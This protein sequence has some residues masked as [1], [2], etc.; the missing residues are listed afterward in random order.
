MNNVQVRL[1]NASK[2]IIIDDSHIGEKAAA[3]LTTN[4]IEVKGWLGAGIKYPIKDKEV[5]KPILEGIKLNK[6][7]TFDL[8]HEQ[9][10][11]TNNSVMNETYLPL[12][13]IHISEPTRPY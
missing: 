5:K 8:D 12:S 11:R 4:A 10:I 1:E 9:L 3:Y 7:I 6:P 2:C 13:L